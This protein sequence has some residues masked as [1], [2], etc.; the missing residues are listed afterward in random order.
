MTGTG[1]RRRDADRAGFSAPVGEIAL[2]LQQIAR[3]TAELGAA[4]TMASVV[5][6]AVTHVAAALRAAVTTLMVREGDQLVMIGGHGLQP[7]IRERWHSF[8]VDANNPASEAVR[9]GRPVS[10]SDVAS[11]EQRY[12]SLRDQVPIRRSIV[13]LPLGAGPA[14]VGVIGMTFDDDWLPGPGELDFLTTFADACGQAIRRV[15]ASTQA[16][17][18]A[19]HLDFLANASAELG[20]SLDYRSTL[21]KVAALV[22]PDLADWCSVDILEDEALTTL[23]VQHVDPAKVAWA[24]ELQ[25]LYPPDPNAPTG[26]PNV[27]RTGV[28]ELYEQITDEM[29]LAAARDEHHLRLARELN[30]HSALVVPLATHSRT[31]GAITLVRAETQRPYGPA[32]LAVA[33]DLARRASTAIENALLHSQTSDIARQLQRAVLPERLDAIPDWTIAAYY[34]P[35][36]HAEVGGDFYDAVPLPDG[37]LAVFIGDVMGHGLAAAAAMAQ[38]RASLRAFITVDPAPDRVIAHLEQMFSL[39]SITR[40]VTLAYAVI[41]PSAGEMQ[42]ANAGHYPPLVVQA[43]GDAHFAQTPPRRPLGTSPDADTATTFELA[44]DDTLLLFTD[45]LIERR[46]ETIDVGLKRAHDN[47]SVLSGAQLHRALSQLVDRVHD[48]GGPDDVTA[49]AVRLG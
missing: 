5:D 38:M 28:S 47:A 42:L 24:W 21:A 27:V 26:A 41:D 16:A 2:Q 13:C 11:I 23:A 9:L 46:G 7:G 36:G 1:D 39:L 15:R 30:L 32:D 19:Q 22:V 33:E 18:R 29:L 34:E 14:P 49:L 43:N 35:G 45:G 37:R 31:L 25:K 17:E 40:L 44:A 12:P 3:V 48:G 6:A 4:E 20:S 10:V 8:P